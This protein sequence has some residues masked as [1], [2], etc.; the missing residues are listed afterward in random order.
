MAYVGTIAILIDVETESEA[1]DAISE[2]MRQLMQPFAGPQSVFR[3]WMWCSGEDELKQ[4][5]PIPSDFQMDDE[6]PWSTT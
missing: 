6:W 2:T 1:M 3:D 4:I 5:G